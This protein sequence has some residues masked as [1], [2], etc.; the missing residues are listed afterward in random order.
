MPNPFARLL[1]ASGALAS[2]FCRGVARRTSLPCS[3]KIKEMI[4][5][6][7]MSE[8]SGTHPHNTLSADNTAVHVFYPF[9]PL[10]GVTLQILCRPRR[11]DGAV[12]V[13]D[14]AGRRLKIPV[15]MLLPE[16]AEIKISQHPHLGKQALLS[17]ATLIT[18]Q[19]DFKDRVH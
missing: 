2:W 17:L 19:L 3:R 8:G 5:P 10:H 13:M 12:C 1:A 6:G 16:C 4:M 7:I 14:R 15:W 9:H 18:S 11:G